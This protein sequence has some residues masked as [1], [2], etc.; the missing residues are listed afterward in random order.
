MAETA[1]KTYKVKAD[2]TADTT[3]N[4]VAVVNDGTG[5]RQVV[6]LGA[7]DGTTT[8]NDGSPANPMNTVE[9]LTDI[10]LALKE[11]IN[12]MVSPPWLDKTNSSLR[13]T[14]AGTSSVSQFAPYIGMSSIWTSQSSASNSSLQTAPNYSP[15]DSWLHPMNRDSWT[16]NIRQ[17]IN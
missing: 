2:N 16:N 17:R 6:V 9:Q 4:S 5:D 7:G 1:D 14:L 12:I 11:L 3:P 15:T 13:A 8:I 10:Y